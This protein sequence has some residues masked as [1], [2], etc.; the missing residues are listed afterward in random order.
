MRIVRSDAG[1]RRR[2][3]GWTPGAIINGVDNECGREQSSV[4]LILR[5]DRGRIDYIDIE[6]GTNSEA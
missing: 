5:Q 3:E 6:V 4:E 2:G 1:Q